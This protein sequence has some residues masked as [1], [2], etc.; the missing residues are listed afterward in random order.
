LFE[1]G[2]NASVGHPHAATSTV[3]NWGCGSLTLD[4]LPLE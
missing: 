4:L 3:L 1:V 2:T